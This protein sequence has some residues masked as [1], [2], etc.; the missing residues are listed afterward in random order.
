VVETERYRTEVVEKSLEAEA[1]AL[2]FRRPRDTQPRHISQIREHHSSALAR[3]WRFWFG[4][5]G[6]EREQQ[7]VGELRWGGEA[8]PREGGPVG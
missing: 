5:V 4:R 6:R 2:T 7:T 8:R 3:A 1:A